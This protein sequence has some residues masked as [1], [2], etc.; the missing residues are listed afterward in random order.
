ML[1]LSHELIWSCACKFEVV[2]LVIIRLQDLRYMVW[3]TSPSIVIYINKNKNFYWCRCTIMSTI[4]STKVQHF[5]QAG[6]ATYP[7][8]AL[9]ASPHVRTTILPQLRLWT[10]SLLTNNGQSLTLHWLTPIS[11]E[12]ALWFKYTT[13]TLLF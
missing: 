11:F 1:S 7:Y 2:W 3:K 13:L 9:S 6:G 4:I 5:P 10:Y 8:S 12:L